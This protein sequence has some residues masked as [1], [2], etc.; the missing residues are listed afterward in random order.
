MPEIMR[1]AAGVL[2]LV[3]PLLLTVACHQPVASNGATEAVASVAAP[4]AEPAP[5]TTSSET[6]SAEPSVAPEVA[7]AT[8]KDAPATSAPIE[9]RAHG[10]KA[11]P[12]PSATVA[13]AT[14]APSE[15]APSAPASSAVVADASSDLA[16]RL[17]A[18]FAGAKTFRARFEQSYSIAAQGVEKHSSGTVIVARPGKLA[19]L[20]DAPN[21]N[22]LVSDGKELHVYDAGSQ[23]DFVQP[24]A[25]AQLPGAFGF[26][27]GQGIAN[28]FHFRPSAAAKPGEAL[29]LGTPVE[30]T[31]A[32]EKVQFTIDT[33]KLEKK[34]VGALRGVLIIDAQHNKN[35]FTFRD[36]VIPDKIGDAEFA[37]TPPAGTSIKRL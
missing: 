12:P 4:T 32:Y 36:G 11:A 18:I 31:P 3:S 28:A 29:L 1:F 16:Q 33:V 13:A 10:A 17:D 22:R 27:M 25:K 15:P 7:T 2:R 19:F 34:D 8:A 5:S 9:K 21:G 24:V 20:Y 26:L 30:A 23:Q 35:R 37:F 14:P 6:P